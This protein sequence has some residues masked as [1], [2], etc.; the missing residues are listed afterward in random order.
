MPRQK[1][2]RLTLRLST[3]TAE[4]LRDKAA[5]LGLLATR[6]ELASRGEGSIS[7]F[8]DRLADAIRRGDVDLSALAVLE[9]GRLLG[10]EARN[11]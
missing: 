10:P 9:Q 2:K 3:G 11:G 5:D 7:M 6:G 8:A 4:I 1:Q